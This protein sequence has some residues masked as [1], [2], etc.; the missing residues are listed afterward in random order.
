M[1]HKVGALVLP[2]PSPAPGQSLADPALDIL[3]EYFQVA[4]ETWLGEAWKSVA[5]KEPIC[6]KVSKHDPEDCDFFE[7]DLP[8]LSVWRSGDATNSRLADAYQESITQLRVLW[9]PPPTTTAK[10]VVRYNFLNGFSKAINEAVT[11]SRIPQYVHSSEVGDAAAE[12]YGSDIED[13]CGI[14]VWRVQSVAPVPVDVPRGDGGVYTYPGYLATIQLTET[15]ETD[16]SPAAGYGVAR[17][18][19]VMDFLRAGETTSQAVVTGAFS[20]AFDDGFDASR[21]GDSFSNSFDSGF[22]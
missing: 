11:L 1:A 6:K 3:V 10:K 5:P 2:A 9:V 4:L 8:L 13:L 12:C 15:N 16:Y 7:G 21:P 19:L 14:D 22:Y 18:E 20:P 17:T